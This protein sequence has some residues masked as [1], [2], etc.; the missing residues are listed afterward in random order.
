VSQVAGLAA[1]GR[2]PL[3]VLSISIQDS[4][5]TNAHWRDR[6]S[7][8]RHEAGR[9]PT[10]THHNGELAVLV[11]DATGVPR[12]DVKGEDAL[13]WRPRGVG[14]ASLAAQAPAAGRGE[15]RNP[16]PPAAGAHPCG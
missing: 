6:F 15:L 14:V 1:S 12:R 3:D 9:T 2:V 8:A 7:R 16:L 13:F 4:L 11:S 5:E 10:L